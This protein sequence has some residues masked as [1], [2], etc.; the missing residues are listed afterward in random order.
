MAINN[1]KLHHFA[2]VTAKS[3]AHDGYHLVSFDIDENNDE[4]RYNLVHDN[5]NYLTI[6]TDSEKGMVIVKKNGKINNVI[7]Y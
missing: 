7:T 5:G 6:Y 3:Y 4:S 2:F 1:N